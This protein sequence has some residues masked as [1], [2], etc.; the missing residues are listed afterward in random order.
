MVNTTKLRTAMDSE[1]AIKPAPFLWMSVEIRIQIYEHLF[2]STRLYS[3]VEYVGRSTIGRNIEIRTVPARNSLAILRT[4]ARQIYEEA[5]GL[6]LGN[7]LF[8]FGVPRDMLEKLSSLP[9]ATISKIRYLGVAGDCLD[10]ISPILPHDWDYSPAM[11]FK[12]LSDLRLHRPTL[13]ASGPYAGDSPVFLEEFIRYGNGWRELHLLTQ[14]STML[15]YGWNPPPRTLM[16][17]SICSV[18]ASPSRAPGPR[19]CASEM[20]GNRGH[21]SPSFELHKLVLGRFSTQT[22]AKPSNKRVRRRS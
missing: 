8:D 22:N 7:V 4:H 2:T 18:V 14:D 5:N 15:K 9:P 10:L 20:V 6:W 21:R 1:N 16:R 12:L 11:A 13:I 19:F 3:A 17:T